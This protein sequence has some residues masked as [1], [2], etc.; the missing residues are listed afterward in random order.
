MKSSTDRAAA[1]EDGSTRDRIIQAT[2][3]LLS[4]Q[5]RD[6]VTTRA[7]ATAAGVQAPAIYRLFGDKQ[8][9]LQAVADAG[10]TLYLDRKRRGPPGEDPL[11]ALRAGWDLHIGFGLENPALFSIMYGDPGAIGSSPAAAKAYAILRERLEALAAAGLLRVPIQRATDMISAAACGSVFML[12]AQDARDRPAELST[13]LREAVI[14]AVSCS[15]SP[16]AGALPVTASVALLQWLPQISDL[17]IGERGLLRELLE[18]IAASE[19]GVASVPL[20]A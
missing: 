6:A 2:I 12:L 14:D 17:S 8:R 9:L 15:M 13:P 1:T 11:D 16:M 3:A 10:F 18:R 20:H 19:R 5:G 7:V 4:E